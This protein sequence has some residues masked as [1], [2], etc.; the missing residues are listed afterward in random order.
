MDLRTEVEEVGELLLR[1]LPLA[2]RDELCG[3]GVA[4]RQE[5]LDVEGGVVEP[6]LRQ[7]T[8]RPVD[9]RMLLGQTDAERA[10]GDRGEA[11]LLPPEESGGEFGVEERSGDHAAILQARQVLGDGVDDPLAAAEGRVER[12]QVPELLG[13]EEDG[14]RTGAARWTR[15]AR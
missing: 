5:H 9:G 10:F 13:V 15:K 14:A 7:G 6:L 12:R 3:K 8:G 11:E 4:D 1:E 2:G